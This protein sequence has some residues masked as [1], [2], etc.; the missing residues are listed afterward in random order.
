M[1]EPC[2][3]QQG[4]RIVYRA[5][6]TGE[7]AAMGNGRLGIG[8]LLHG[9]FVCRDADNKY[10]AVVHFDGNTFDTTVAY[11]FIQ[12]E[13]DWAIKQAEQALGLET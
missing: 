2:A 1:A 7:A 8:R 13:R 10:M 9:I 5:D 11:R 6:S 3:Y 12:S 4:Q